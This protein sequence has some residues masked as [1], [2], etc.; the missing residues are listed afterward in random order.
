MMGSNP[1][2]EEIKSF[3]NVISKDFENAERSLNLMIF[4]FENSR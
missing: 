4:G 2:L 1:S 3:L